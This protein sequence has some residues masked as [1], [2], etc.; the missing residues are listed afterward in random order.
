[1]RFKSLL[2]SNDFD[3]VQIRFFGDFPIPCDDDSRVAVKDI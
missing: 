2:F 1:M 3:L